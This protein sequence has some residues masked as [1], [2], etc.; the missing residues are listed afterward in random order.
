[1]LQINQGLTGENDSIK[2][3]IFSDLGFSPISET[4][5]SWTPLVADFDNDGKRIFSSPTDS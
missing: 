5:W 1:M 3:P 4:D 2:H